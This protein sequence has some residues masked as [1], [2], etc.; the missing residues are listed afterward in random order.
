MYGVPRAE[1]VEPE[2][3]QSEAEQDIEA[4][5]DAEIHRLKQSTATARFQPIRIDMKCGR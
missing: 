3:D 4:E 5:I 2:L 1:D